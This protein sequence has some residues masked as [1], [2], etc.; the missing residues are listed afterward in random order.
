M[1]ILRY[2][3]SGAL[4]GLRFTATKRG[5]LRNINRCSGS[6]HEETSRQ[7]PL[8][9]CQAILNFMQNFFEIRST[10]R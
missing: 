7:S 6:D 5:L 1:E 9:H 8:S 3:L 4:E 10:S 2:S